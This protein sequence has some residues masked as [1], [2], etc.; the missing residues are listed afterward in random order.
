MAHTLIFQKFVKER[1]VDFI[2][3]SIVNYASIY[4]NYLQ[5]KLKSY[6]QIHIDCLYAN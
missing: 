2:D 3:G 1:E 5:K 6:P 4:S